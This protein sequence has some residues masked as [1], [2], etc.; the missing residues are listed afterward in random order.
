MLAE[1]CIENFAVIEKLLVR[2]NPGLTVLTGETG[3]GKSIIIDALQA[4]LG[5]R[6]GADVVRGD[7]RYAGVE[8]VF[9]WAEKIP[10]ALTAVLEEHGIE[11]EESLILRREVQASGR[12]SARING[13]AVP[14]S[15]LGAAGAL[16]VDIHGQSDHL[17]ILRRDRQLDVLDRYG[18]LLGMR[19]QV[20]AA[21]REYGAV[22]VE[23]RVLQEGQAEAE[24]RLDLL[25]FQVKEIEDAELV[26]DEEE[27]LEAER[28]LL[29]NAER[30]TLRA[31][32]A[33][34]ALAGDA[35]R[36]A[37][38]RAVLSL[39]DL[40]DIDASLQGLAD[41]LSA[42]DVELDDISG[43]IRQYRDTVEYDP[44]R[45]AAIEERCDLLSRLKRKYGT[46][47]AEVI[48]FGTLARSEMEDVENLDE[49][50]R[51]LR[52]AVEE[53]SVAAGISAHDLS[54]ARNQVAATL[55]Q[56]VAEA[57]QGLGLKGTN[58]Q[59]E[60][61]RVESADG[62]LLPGVVERYAFT[63]TGVDNVA[64]LASF[65]LG[66]P[67]RSLE[68]VASGGETSRFLLAL[69][70]VLAA[71]DRTPTLIFDEVDVGVG[72][73]SGAVVGERLRDLSRTHQVLSITHLPQVAALADEHLAVVKVVSD[74]RTRVDVRIL[75]EQERVDEL[76]QMMSGSETE[77][78]RRSAE[79]LLKTSRGRP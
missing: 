69:K 75:R 30:L 74:G 42:A 48:T 28:N 58:F 57:L 55:S 44:R 4:S 52:N 50:L 7:A 45:L 37:L 1:L 2:F 13:R 64:F 65:N 12:S 14:L 60:L 70:S 26:D 32:T 78:A 6:I 31:T 35:L 3:A 56:A 15:V 66:E 49:R 16:L 40:T 20:A 61:S 18:N 24:R 36:E 46:T 38:G 72:G 43:E 77:V 19:A 10:E 53:S 17:S 71:A 39:R 5:S 54:I 8:A 47:V 79:E 25:R 76:A 51:A 68:K 67:L 41:R 34:E 33:H 62:L 29:S 22:R 27:A 11:E 23:L 73:R 59:I 63:Q 9:A 21:V